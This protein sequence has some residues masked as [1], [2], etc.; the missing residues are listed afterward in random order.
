M[1]CCRKS[2]AAGVTDEF[3]AL[4]VTTKT[5]ESIGTVG[6]AMWLFVSISRTDRGREIGGSPSKTSPTMA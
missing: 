3:I 6:Q 2:Y 5:G 1:R 4:V